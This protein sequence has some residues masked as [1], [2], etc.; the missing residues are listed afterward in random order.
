MRMINKMVAQLHI[1][2]RRIWTKIVHMWI[3]LNTKSRFVDGEIDGEFYVGPEVVDTDNTESS[4]AGFGLSL[5]AGVAVGVLT[6][7]IGGVLA[8]L[9]VAGVGSVSS[10]E[11][12]RRKKTKF[13]CSGCNQ[14][15]YSNTRY[16][17]G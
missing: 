15:K 17:C 7:G 1:N 6:G 12:D 9:A 10:I 8:G 4:G 16:M 14:E 2:Y 11:A 3:Q 5:I 13:K